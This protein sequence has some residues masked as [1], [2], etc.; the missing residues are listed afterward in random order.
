MLSVWPPAAKTGLAAANFL[1][2]YGAVRHGA[3]CGHA[4]TWANDA[5][6]AARACSARASGEVAV[7]E[8]EISRAMRWARSNDE[9][10]YRYAATCFL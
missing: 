10:S 6:V 3:N 9:R 4:H 2:N 7:R 1:T 5:G 8:R